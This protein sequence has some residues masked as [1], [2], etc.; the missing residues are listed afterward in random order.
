[1]IDKVL[2]SSVIV[3]ICRSSSLFCYFWIS[4][5]YEDMLYPICFNEL[6]T[7]SFNKNPSVITAVIGSVP[8]AVQ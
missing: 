7:H 1:M 3:N 5:A 4:F 2:K 8:F 6:S